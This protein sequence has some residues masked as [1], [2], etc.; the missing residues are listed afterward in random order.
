V[1][2]NAHNREAVANLRQVGLA[3]R[4]VRIFETYFPF[5]AHVARDE[6]ERFR[7]AALGNKPA[8]AKYSEFAQEVITY[9]SNA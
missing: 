2:Y 5:D 3:R 4:G 6:R 7:I 1:L 9:D 8:S